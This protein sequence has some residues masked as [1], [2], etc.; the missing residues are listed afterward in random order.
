[1]EGLLP[2]GLKGLAVGLTHRAA[3]ATALAKMGEGKLT[4]AYPQL[5]V[6]SRMSLS[7]THQDEYAQDGLVLREVQDYLDDTR[8]TTS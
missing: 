6:P 7:H 3:S 5:L 1:M 8:C 4:L 2:R